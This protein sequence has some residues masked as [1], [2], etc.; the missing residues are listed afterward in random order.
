F[1]DVIVGYFRVSGF[2]LLHEALAEAEK[3]RVLVGIS[4]GQTEYELIDAHRSQGAFDFASHSR[5]RKTVRDAVTG[6]VANAADEQRV[7]EGLRAFLRMLEEGRL[8]V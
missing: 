5:V 7:E 6:E 3:V 4:T 8:E 2:H 1:L